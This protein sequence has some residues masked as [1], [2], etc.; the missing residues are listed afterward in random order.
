MKLKFSVNSP[1]ISKLEQATVEDY[2][3]I[4]YNCMLKMENLAKQR[5]PVD[6]GRLRMSINL[7]P[8]NYG[9]KEYTLSDGVDYGYLV[10]YGTRAMIT[11]HGVH[12]PENPI[13]DWEAKRK[14]N[15]VGQTLP[16]F[17]PALLEVKRV[18]LEKYWQKLLNSK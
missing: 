10:E 16:F 5:T 7:F 2:K 1:D 4:L 14:R 9:A 12:D 11:A 18:W 6:T 13:T 17:R 15:A 8:K 3:K